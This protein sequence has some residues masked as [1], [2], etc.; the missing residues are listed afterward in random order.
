MLHLVSAICA[1]RQ[2]TVLSEAGPEAV[3][4]VVDH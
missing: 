2:A 1:V 3:E 4:I